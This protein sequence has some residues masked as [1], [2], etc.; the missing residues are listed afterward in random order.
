MSRFIVTD[1]GKIG[2]NEDDYISHT[3][4]R[5]IPGNQ[6]QQIAEIILRTRDGKRESIGYATDE[7]MLADAINLGEKL[8][9][10]DKHE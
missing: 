10:G 2:F 5:I 1:S 6:F 7:E 8:T 4:H 9:C 3:C